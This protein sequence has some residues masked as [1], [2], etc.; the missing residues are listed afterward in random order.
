MGEGE[1]TSPDHNGLAVF[2]KAKALHQSGDLTA[3]EA[4]YEA[5]KADLEA[6]SLTPSWQADLLHLL[7]AL[8]IQ[9]I[10][11]KNVIADSAAEEC[12]EGD[13]AVKTTLT[14]AQEKRS[15]EGL[16]HIE[17]AAKLRPEDAKI[18]QSLGIARSKIAGCKEKDD[19]QREVLLEG[20]Y[21]AFQR[22]ADLSSRKNQRPLLMKAHYML[23]HLEK[24]KPP[25]RRV[26]VLRS[27]LEICPEDPRCHY[28]LASCLREL[29]ENDEAASEFEAHI[30]LAEALPASTPGQSK[31]QESNAHYRV[32]SAR[33]W[34]AVLRGR[35]T[36]CAPEDY[37]SSVFDDY[38]DKFEHHLVNELKYQTPQVL[39]Q[40]LAAVLRNSGI[41][42]VG[43][44]V[45][46]GCGTGLMGP[47]VK[48]LG[49]VESLEGIDLSARMLEKAKDKGVYDVLRRCNL[50]DAFVPRNVNQNSQTAVPDFTPDASDLFGL[51]V[52]SDVFVY[53]GD[54]SS[55]F[56]V[57][58]RWIHPRGLFGFSVEDALDDKEASETLGYKLTDTGRYIHTARYVRSLAREY[59][60]DICSQKAMIL[61]YNGGK[62]VHGRLF[63]LT[64][65]TESS[66]EK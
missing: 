39:Q 65:L 20:A 29:H 35:T 47:L 6:Q 7:G 48:E 28:L 61:R 58:R 19:P 33:H 32:A 31:V 63:V 4:D 24:K 50:E 54:L 41:S 46:L 53:V 2:T 18:L 51:V 49:T 12:E 11:P 13:E 22:A 66:F 55:V 45:D 57:T 59:S 9:R 5:A 26:R 30:R 56:A 34:A 38:A 16:K 42:S 62:P 36:A 14:T 52:A 23:F 40:Q 10:F 8:I 64:P 15:E 17:K 37:V 27:I 44:V 1:D 3:A 60:F 21:E 43:R 25:V